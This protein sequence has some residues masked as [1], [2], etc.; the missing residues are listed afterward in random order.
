M[1]NDNDNFWA[2]MLTIILM[3]V[4]FAVGVHQCHRRAD[5]HKRGGRY[6]QSRE[7]LSAGECVQPMPD[8]DGGV[9]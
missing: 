7:P 9:R 4:L 8:P 2:W 6:V 3:T 1:S 5:C